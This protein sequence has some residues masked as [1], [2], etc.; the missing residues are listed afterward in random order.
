MLRRGGWHDSLGTITAGAGAEA[1]ETTAAKARMNRLS[2]WAWWWISI[3]V[4]IVV[5]DAIASKPPHVKPRSLTEYFKHVFSHGW[6]RA[7]GVAILT[8]LFIHLAADVGPDVRPMECAW[9]P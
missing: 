6:K 1:A 2:K 9:C 8:V 7:V 4:A 3:I 5:T